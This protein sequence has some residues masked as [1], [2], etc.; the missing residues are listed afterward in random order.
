VESTYGPIED[1]CFID[2]TDFSRLFAIDFAI[3]NGNLGRWDTSNVIDMSRMFFGAKS[4]SSDISRWKVDKVTNMEGMFL[5]ALK[6]NSDLKWWNVSKVTEM[7][8]MFEV[9]ATFNH[10]LCWWTIPKSAHVQNMFYLSACPRPADPFSEPH[11]QFD[12][13]CHKCIYT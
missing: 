12:S 2:I 9:A 13:I 8:S 10:D 7:T 6:F 4:F 11:S 1:W 3:F 5:F